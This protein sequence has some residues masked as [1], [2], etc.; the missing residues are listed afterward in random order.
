[1]TDKHLTQ[2]LRRGWPT[3]GPVRLAAAALGFSAV[4]SAAGCGTAAGVGRTVKTR[5]ARLPTVLAP[6]PPGNRSPRVG[7]PPWWLTIWGKDAIASFGSYGPEPGQVDVMVRLRGS[8]RADMFSGLGDVPQ[9]GRSRARRRHGQVPD[10]SAAQAH[11]RYEGVH[12]SPAAKRH[13][14]HRLPGA[15]RLQRRQRAWFVVTG[16]SVAPDKSTTMAMYESYDQTAPISVADVDK[17]LSDSRMTWVTHP[18]INRAGHG[19]KIEKLAAAHGV[20]APR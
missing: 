5:Q 4:L 13:D 17:L 3:M 9:A 8:G 6:R 14:S 15:V 20:D 7:L 16:V 11:G 19:L 12:L 2:A 10:H 18:A 1:M